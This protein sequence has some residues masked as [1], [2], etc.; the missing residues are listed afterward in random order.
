MH[1]DGSGTDD[2]DGAAA[3]RAALGHMVL[4]F[5]SDALRDSASE[6]AFEFRETLAML[7]SLLLE[8]YSDDDELHGVVQARVDSVA[9]TI[10]ASSAGIDPVAD[11]PQPSAL[12]FLVLVRSSMVR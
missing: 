12:H 5:F 7:M 9:D 2:T 8:R 3:R 11:V 1:G 4:L 6:C 10:R